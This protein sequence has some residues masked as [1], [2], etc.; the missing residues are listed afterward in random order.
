MKT[1]LRKHRELTPQQRMKRQ[2][3]YFLRQM[4]ED[5]TLTQEEMAKALGW[6]NRQT[7]S[8]KES[9]KRGVELHEA[10]AIYKVV[11]KA[12]EIGKEDLDA[13]RREAQQITEDDMRNVV[14]E[15]S[16]HIVADAEG[17]RGEAKHRRGD[18]EA[19]LMDKW[20]RLTPKKR[21]LMENLL[22]QLLEE[23]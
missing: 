3:G 8:N 19:D 5:V 4:R 17:A 2:V 6:E 12:K 22:E 11:Q 13:L 18:K 9:G 1:G 10:I 21:K 23:E 16:I 20:M 14:V 15:S 7:V